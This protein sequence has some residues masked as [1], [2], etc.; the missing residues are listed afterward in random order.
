MGEEEVE[1]ERQNMIKDYTYTL[2]IYQV[3]YVLI[4]F[5]ING[6]LNKMNKNN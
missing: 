3:Y 1:P 5:F 4:C 2:N 6:P